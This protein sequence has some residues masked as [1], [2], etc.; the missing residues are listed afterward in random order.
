MGAWTSCNSRSFLAAYTSLPSNG[1]SIGSAVF[2]QHTDTDADV[3]HAYSNRPHLCTQRM[4]CCLMTRYCTAKRYAPVYRSLTGA[5]LRYGAA[6]S[7]MHLKQHWRRLRCWPV[8]STFQHEHRVS[9]CCSIVTTAVKCIVV[10]G[11]DIVLL[12]I[13][14][15][16]SIA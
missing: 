16:R 1:I 10:G 2:A 6:T 15:D 7:R 14:T 9:Y 12:D 11:W 5:Y 13:R 4:R 3:R 8:G